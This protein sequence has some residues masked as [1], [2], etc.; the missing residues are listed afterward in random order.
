M[1]LFRETG[2]AGRTN[3]SGR[4][5]IR[6]AERT[7]EAVSQLV[8]ERSQVSVCHLKQELDLL[9]GSCRGILKDNLHLHPYRLQTTHETFTICQQTDTTRVLS[10]IY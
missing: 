10:A 2:T 4:P 6:N 7:K 5:T 9:C 3:C 8:E 1:Q